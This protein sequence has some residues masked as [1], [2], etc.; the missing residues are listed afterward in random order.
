MQSHV[1]TVI[2][3]VPEF[4]QVIEEHGVSEEKS[5]LNYFPNKKTDHFFISFSST[6]INK[7]NQYVFV[8]TVRSN[9]QT[10][11]TLTVDIRKKIY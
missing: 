8:T 10:M 1:D 5:S 2:S 6:Q 9:I 11:I 4:R 3:H 7:W